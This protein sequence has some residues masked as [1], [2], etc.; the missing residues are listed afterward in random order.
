MTDILRD[1]LR[2]HEG[3]RLKPYLDSEGKLTIGIGRNL[4]DVGITEDEAYILLDHDIKRTKVDLFKALPWAY[5]LDEA[6]QAVLLNMA[7]NMGVEGLLHF[8]QTLAAVES[9]EWKFA[10]AYMLDSKWAKQVGNRAV[11]LAKVMETGEL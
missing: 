3:L 2:G 9:G 1:M 4:D 7:F 5:N 6:R 8:K 11:Y 10:A